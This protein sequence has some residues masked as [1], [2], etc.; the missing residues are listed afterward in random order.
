VYLSVKHE[1]RTLDV[2]GSAKKA[3]LSD[4]IAWDATITARDPDLIAAYDKLKADADRVAAFI[5]TAGVADKEVTFSSIATS[6][7]FQREVI[8]TPPPAGAANSA[9]PPPPTIMP[10]N[11]VEMYVLTQSVH[12]ESR[13]MNKVNVISRSITSLIKEGAEIESGSPRYLYSRLSELK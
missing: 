8:P 5:K 7:I 6:K 10:T 9:N 13:D 4:T 12:I 11:K 3:I 1:P 2:K